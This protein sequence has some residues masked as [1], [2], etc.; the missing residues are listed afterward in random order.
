MFSR[1][2]RLTLTHIH[3]KLHNENFYWKTG[4]YGLILAGTVHFGFLILFCYLGFYML[5]AVNVV[6]VLIYWYC[7]FGI[8]LK[9]LEKKDDGEIGWLVYIELV[10]HNVVATYYLGSEAGFQYYIYMLAA[11]PFFISSYSM[12]I[13]LLRVTSALFIAVFLDI[14]EVFQ[15]PKIPIGE[16]V[17]SGLYQMNML[18]AFGALVLLSYLYISKERKYY[19]SLLDTHSSAKQGDEHT[20]D[21][22]G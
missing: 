15:Y 16:A 19:K 11:L 2:Q 4:Y 6:S 10:G 7:I 13:Y 21:Q 17:L 18:I 8:G 9:A 20:E 22:T 12:P 5:A 14:Y 1:K 3:K